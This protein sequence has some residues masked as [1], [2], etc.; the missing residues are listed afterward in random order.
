MADCWVGLDLGQFVDYACVQVLGRSIAINR[1]TGLP[2]R[3]SRGG[4]LYRWDLIGM[5]RFPLRTPYTQIV[6]EVV[7]IATRPELRPKPRLIVDA[8]GVGQGVLEM[9]RT[10]MAPHSTIDVWGI[11]ITAGETWRVAGRGLIHCSKIQ[12]T[13]SLDAVLGSRRLKIAKHPATGEPINGADVL[14]RELAAFRAKITKG[15]NETSGADSGAHDDAV[16]SVAL[17]IWAGSLPFMRMR[18]LIDEQ[19]D[20]MLRAREMAAIGKERLEVEA[21][22]ALALKREQQEEVD[23]K[24]ASWE[25]RKRTDEERQRNP[26]DPLWW[27]G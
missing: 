13:G 1:E 16:L 10:A 18:E 27:G 24:R 8:T 9:V 7:K 19:D 15:G 14:K 17:P 21:V 26:N 25:A 11:V 2:W 6:S 5:R 23:Y 3:D 20:P 12:I 4:S 22:E